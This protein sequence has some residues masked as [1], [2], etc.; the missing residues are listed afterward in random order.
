MKTITYL[1]S[2]VFL[3]LSCKKDAP[4][5]F[6]ALS[7]RV[8]NTNSDSLVITSKS[9]YKKVIKLKA[10]GVFKDTIRSNAGV[11]N[12][13]D[14]KE[15]A[16]L[17]AEA[18]DEIEMT[19]N[20]KDFDE[21]LKFTGKGA[22]PSNFKALLNLKQEK[23]MEDDSIFTLSELEIKKKIA[24][25][26]TDFTKTIDTAVGLDSLFIK[27]QKEGFD[28]FLIYLE[29]R[30]SQKRSI[31]K[32]L[33]RGVVSP[34]FEGYE[35]YKGG[36]TSLDDLKGKYV[37]IDLWATWCGPCKYEIPYLKKVEKAYHDKNI[38]F[39]SVSIDKPSDRE[40]WLTMVENENLKGVQLYANGDREFL[41][42][43]KVSGIPR[44]ILLDP[45]GNIITADAPRP[46][47]EKL[48]KLFD[49]LNI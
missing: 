21:S 2:V 39:V 19:L 28:G 13:F 10:D 29:K 15:Y 24:A 48:I 18:G 42:A 26:R 7:G 35:N 23:L 27:E 9:G 43:Y 49:E 25:I 6:V 14:G 34:K 45:E 1:L 16:Y 30:H 36:K 11:F 8:I 22:A 32:D 40:K 3:L 12:V 31:L 33:A 17:Y 20:A 44:F 47:D 46:S 41:S 5:D 37:Y 38:E 4:K